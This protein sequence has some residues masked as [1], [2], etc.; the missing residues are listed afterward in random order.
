MGTRPDYDM[1]KD[2]YQTVSRRVYHV[3]KGWKTRNMSVDLENG[4]LI[5]SME[6]LEDTASFPP[7]CSRFSVT[8]LHVAFHWCSTVGKRILTR[9]LPF[10][11]TGRRRSRRGINA[12]ERPTI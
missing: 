10:N 12:H 11:H 3:W 9:L 6:A 4:P 1:P 8:L 2:I 5:W 7:F